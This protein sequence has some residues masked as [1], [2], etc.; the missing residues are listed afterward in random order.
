MSAKPDNVAYET[1]VNEALARMRE[2]ASASLSYEVDRTS[3]Q[4]VVRRATTTETL[5]ASD[6]VAE[7]TRSTPR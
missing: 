5:F 4:W 6:I 3:G 7:V 2:A 1:I